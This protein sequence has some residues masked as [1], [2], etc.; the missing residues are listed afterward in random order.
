MAYDD[1]NIFARVLRGEIPTEAVYEDD[2]CL[3]FGDINPQAPIHI[4]VIPK[5]RIAKLADAGEEDKAVLGHLLWAVR[6]IA[7]RKGFA[8]DGYRVVINNGARA[9]QTV[10]H[11]HVHVLAG[12]DMNWPPG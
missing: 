4:L 11:L 12:R 8:E 1:N 5:A 10:F 9:N 6:E 2:H 7:H 3:A